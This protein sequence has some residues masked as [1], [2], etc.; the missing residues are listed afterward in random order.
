MASYN[1]PNGSSSHFMTVS[2]PHADEAKAGSRM[3]PG[4]AYLPTS[5]LQHTSRQ[6][7]HNKYGVE[8]RPRSNAPLN[9]TGVP[10]EYGMSYPKTQWNPA[11]LLNPKSLQSL[12]R[13]E[14]YKP[15]QT[16]NLPSSQPV[17]H[18][19]TPGGASLPSHPAPQHT[20]GKPSQNGQTYGDGNGMGH[21][22]ERMH[23]V[24][25]RDLLPQKRQKLKHEGEV[26]GKKEHF[27]GGGRNGVLGE[28]MREKREEGRKEAASNGTRPS[29]DLTGG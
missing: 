5:N 17:F 6:D 28:Y 22:L 24:T 18:F 1:Q 8:G 16:Q 20:F 7:S 3:A 27:A 25:E 21:M 26:D 13:K 19:D 10:L 11:A 2:H 4:G 23:N 14:E 15:R 12:P 29:V 9:G